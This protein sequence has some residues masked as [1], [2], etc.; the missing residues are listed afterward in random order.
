MNIT[1]YVSVRLQLCLFRL[2]ISSLNVFLL[3]IVTTFKAILVKVL[4]SVYSEECMTN[5]N[6]VDF[7]DPRF[8]R[9][10]TDH[11]DQ[12]RL[13]KI[14]FIFFSKLMALPSGRLSSPV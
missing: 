14:G 5:F 6:T 10:F 1:F 9:T 13:L 8:D 7:K 4:E 3:T 2:F 12:I 11:S